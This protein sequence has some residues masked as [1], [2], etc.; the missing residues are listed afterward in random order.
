LNFLCQSF[1]SRIQKVFSKQIKPYAWDK[2]IGIYEEEKKKI[3]EKSRKLKNSISLDCI[4]NLNSLA[5]K[6]Q[7]WP[8]NALKMNM[9]N[10]TVGNLVKI[11]A[12]KEKRLKEIRN[13]FN[14]W[15]FVKKILD[16]QDRLNEDK[17]HIEG[18]FE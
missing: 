7:K 4:N 16:A 2:L 15:V 6:C 12:L 18:F 13:A 1:C 17:Q 10:N 3:I 8:N 11:R 14:K 9:K 5:P